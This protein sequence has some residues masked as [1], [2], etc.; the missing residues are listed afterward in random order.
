MVATVRNNDFI[1]LVTE[2]T[3]FGLHDLKLA[4]ETLREIDLPSGVV[5]N[6]ADDGTATIRD[7]CDQMGLPVLLE[8][9]YQRDIAESYSR[10]EG[11]LAICPDLREPLRTL[12]AKD[13]PAMVQA[14]GRL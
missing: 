3:P 6:R 1:I 13:I 12:L 8:I 4:V 2:P 7:Y 10:G 14:E 5:I 9:P 11:L